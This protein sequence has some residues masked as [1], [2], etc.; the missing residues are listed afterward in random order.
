MGGGGSLCWSIRFCLLLGGKEAEGGF[1]ERWVRVPK[2]AFG[3]TVW[4][5][6]KWMFAADSVWM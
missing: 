5:S 1:C 2:I 6:F 4:V 3:S